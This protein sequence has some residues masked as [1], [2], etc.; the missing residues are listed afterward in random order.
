[1]PPASEPRQEVQS[2][3]ALLPLPP[4]YCPLPAPRPFPLAL[5]RAA[6]AEAA[7]ALSA[8]REGESIQH[9]AGEMTEQ[10]TQGLVTGPE[11]Q[12]PPKLD[13]SQ[14]CRGE[15]NSDLHRLAWH[16]WG[17]CWSPLQP[18]LPHQLILHSSLSRSF[19]ACQE[20]FSL[21]SDS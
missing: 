20:V 8:S 7:A 19:T 12:F 9:G 21:I 1:M 13:S 4:A 14:A 10:T 17:T 15:G 18:L 3:R 11:K 2:M 6:A 16:C 5:L